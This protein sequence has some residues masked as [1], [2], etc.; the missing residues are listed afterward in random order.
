MFYIIGSLSFHMQKLSI[1]W[2]ILILINDNLLTYSLYIIA[3]LE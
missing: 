3:G 1:F 2:E